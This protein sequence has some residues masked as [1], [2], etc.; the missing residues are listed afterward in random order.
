MIQPNG[1]QWNPPELGPGNVTIRIKFGFS[2]LRQIGAPTVYSFIIGLNHHQPVKSKLYD[3]IYKM[4]KFSAGIMVTETGIIHQQ[5]LSCE[6]T[7]WLSQCY[8]VLSNT[9]KA[10]SN[11]I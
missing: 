11:F 9:N 7:R 6:A 10:T 1:T 8:T 5:T 3:V 4:T 2:L